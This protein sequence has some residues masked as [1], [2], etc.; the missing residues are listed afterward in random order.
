M[1][2]FVPAPT[3][4]PEIEQLKNSE[5]I[6]LKWIHVNYWLIFSGNWAYVILFV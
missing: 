5:L 2:F 4:R 3:G 6:P 1:V